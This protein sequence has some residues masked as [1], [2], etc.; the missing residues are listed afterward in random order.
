MQLIK[1]KN[2][3]ITKKELKVLKSIVDEYI[4]I[5]EIPQPNNWK[6]LDNNRLWLKI[7]GQINV[8]GGVK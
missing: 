3:N 7:V 5:T 4:Y 6:K 2:M 1:R 8:I